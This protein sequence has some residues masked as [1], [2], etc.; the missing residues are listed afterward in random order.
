M[1]V[2]DMSEWI[3]VFESSKK[4]EHD[5]QVWVSIEYQDGYKSQAYAVWDNVDG[6]WFEFDS[7]T[8]LTQKYAKEKGWDLDFAKVTHWM[9]LPEPPK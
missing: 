5:Q 4:P 7:Q 9:P 2:I 8:P 1:K 3:S 6:W